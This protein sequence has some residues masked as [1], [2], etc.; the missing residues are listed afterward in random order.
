MSSTIAD[1]LLLLISVLTIFLISSEAASE[2]ILLISDIEV[3]F[4]VKEDSVLLKFKEIRKEEN[5]YVAKFRNKDI[6]VDFFIENFSSSRVI[7][8]DIVKV[9]VMKRVKS[10]RE[11]L[12][13]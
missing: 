7:S 1:T 12:T 10:I 6:A 4:E 5:N 9:D 3:F 8:P 11:L 13:K 2:A